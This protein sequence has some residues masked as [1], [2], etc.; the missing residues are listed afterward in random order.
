MKRTICPNADCDA[1]G[2]LHFDRGPCCPVCN[3]LVIHL[4]STPFRRW[5][6]LSM[7]GTSLL[8]IIVIIAIFTSGALP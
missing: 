1:Y 6:S 7:I 3:G 8:I 2:E 4:R 5:I